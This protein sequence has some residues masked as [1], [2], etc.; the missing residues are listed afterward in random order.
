[1]VIKHRWKWRN[2]KSW[3]LSEI[4]ILFTGTKST[5]FTIKST[6]TSVY[7]QHF[8]IGRYTD[9]QGRVL[10]LNWFFP[11]L[12]KVWYELLFVYHVSLW[13]AWIIVTSFLFLCFV[14]LIYFS[15]FTTY[16]FN[17]SFRDYT[18]TC[19]ISLNQLNWNLKSIYIRRMC[20]TIIVCFFLYI[21]CCISSCFLY[22]HVGALSN[23]TYID[24]ILLPSIFDKLF[25]SKIW[26]TFTSFVPKTT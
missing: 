13:L 3:V 9:K 7:E 8:D 20:W 23:T 22:Q 5:H 17:F 25:T 4:F 11:P 19:C 16:L 24:S 6:T 14:H 26:Y 2:I 12:Q 15:M 21:T 18:I 1:M 10:S